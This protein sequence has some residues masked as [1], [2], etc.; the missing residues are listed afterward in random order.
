MKNINEAIT[1]R[2]WRGEMSYDAVMWTTSAM[3]IVVDDTI[4]YVN[5]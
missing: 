5:I 2:W 3:V 1:E 4:G